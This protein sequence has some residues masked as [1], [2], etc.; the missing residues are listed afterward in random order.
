MI[1]AV[2]FLGMGGGLGYA[3]FTSTGDGDSAASTGT[4]TPWQLDADASVGDP[5]IPGGPETQ[6][7]DFTV[8]NPSSGNQKLNLVTVA[9]AND[10]G[11]AWT[12]VAGCSAADYTVSITTAPTYDDVDAAD[13]R[14]GQATISMN[15]RNATQDG[16]KNATVPLYFHAS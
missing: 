2:L 10:D 11:T 5:L 15:N 12:S 7:V 9:V 16:C 8:T 13:T 1:T 4:S 3:W 14:S 6:T